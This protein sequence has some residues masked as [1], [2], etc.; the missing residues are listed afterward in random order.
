MSGFFERLQK[1]WA[2]IRGAP[3]S[4]LTAVA[5][6]AGAIWFFLRETNHG[7]LSAKDATIETLKAQNDS[8]KEKLSGATP[9]EAKARI[10]LEALV[11]RIEPRRLSHEQKKAIT[12]NVMLPE[13]ASYLLSIT[14]DMSCMDCNQYADEFSGVLSEAHW[15]IRTPMVEKPGTKSPKGIAVLSPD[16]NN[17]LPEAAAL[18]R[19]LRAAD[20]P[21]D[22]MPGSDMNFGPQGM[23]VP[24]SAMVIT[25]KATS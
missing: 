17:P 10:A 21:F 9:E 23:P 7:T 3:W 12:A 4:F 6:V 1:E 18:M 24:I 19:A 15:V 22:M 13:G 2:V 14:S 16:P 20:I 25:A 5:I 11:S 8:C